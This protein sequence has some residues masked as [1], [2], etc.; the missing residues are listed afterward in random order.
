MDTRS[1][2]EKITSYPSA[3]G[4]NCFCL[5]SG[6]VAFTFGSLWI[7]HCR[8]HFSWSCML[9]MCLI[10]LYA[11]SEATFLEA[12]KKYRL[13]W[14]METSKRVILPDTRQGII[15]IWCRDLVPEKSDYSVPGPESEA[16]VYPWRIHHSLFCHLC[17]IGLDAVSYRGFCE[18]RKLHITVFHDL[19]QHWAFRC[20]FQIALVR[21]GDFCGCEC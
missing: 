10:G 8:A 11:T 15:G 2:L 13:V 9:V 16:L 17:S 21:P 7:P 19:S 5:G 6:Q 18:N 20:Y 3:K 1:A 12:F 14:Q 4:S